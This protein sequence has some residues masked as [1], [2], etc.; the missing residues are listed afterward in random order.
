MDT[1][2]QR[3]FDAVIRKFNTLT[4]IYRNAAAKSGLSVS[5]FWVW[6][7]LMGEERDFTQREICC[8]C[9][10]PKQTVNT[11]VRDMVR[12]KLAT[13]EAIPLDRSRKR[14]HLT[15]PGRARGQEL[16]ADALTAERKA[17]LGLSEEAQLGALRFLEE[18]LPRLDRT[19]SGEA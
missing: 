8:V 17:F 6:H 15:A 14:I 2:P 12:Q 1:E 9:G 10:L 13:L 5:E 19:V 3:R 4:G 16:M 7:T 11:I 18:Y